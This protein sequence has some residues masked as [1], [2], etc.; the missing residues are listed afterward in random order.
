MLFRVTHITDYRYADPV[1]EAYL[2]LRLQPLNRHDQTI[3][4][5][6]LKIS[7]WR[8]TSGYQDYFGNEVSFLSLPF[9]H[10]RLTIQSDSLVETHLS[11]P[12]E[13]S[14][15]ISIQEARQLLT[16]ALPTVF[17]YLQPTSM[18]KTG[19]ESIQ[20]ARRYL[21]GR[22][23]LKDGL[24]ALNTAVFQNFKYRPGVTKFTTDLP[25][26]WR[27]RVGVCQDFA[28]IMLSVLRTAGLPA[29]YVCGYIET[30]P[31]KPV[32]GERRN[33]IG[34]VATHAWVE[35]LIPGQHWVALDPTNNRWCG[36]QHIAVSFGRDAGEASPIRGTFKGSRA[37]SLKVQ[38]K[39]RR[40]KK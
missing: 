29:R 37:Q 10:S 31:P 24:D 17:D 6:K 3:R 34:S 22:V 28:H 2:E 12:P 9:R 1:A 35:V 23:S 40:V 21:R 27:D 33:L 5:H 11:K 30:A 7:P 14:L 8:Q 4:E 38:V 25:V 26:I 32:P 13:G 16:H 19:R 15:E 18:V 20:W 36:E 39:M